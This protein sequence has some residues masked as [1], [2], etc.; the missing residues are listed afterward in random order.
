MS[1][2]QDQ[3]F[4]TQENLSTIINSIKGKLFDLSKVVFVNGIIN[5]S[6]EIED[7]RKEFFS[8]NKDLRRYEDLLRGVKRQA[9]QDSKDPDKRKAFFKR[10]N[11]EHAK[12]WYSNFHQN[13]QRKIEEFNTEH[14]VR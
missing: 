2:S 4:Y 7:E 10:Q 5:T 13:F 11:E 6:K 8:L 12:R 1:A 9:R 14:K 3:E